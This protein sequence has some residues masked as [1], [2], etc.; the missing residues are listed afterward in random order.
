MIY[1]YRERNIVSYYT[2]YEYINTVARA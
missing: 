1:I 2:I